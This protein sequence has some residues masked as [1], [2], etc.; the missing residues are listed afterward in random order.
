MI[1]RKRYLHKHNNDATPSPKPAAGDKR[2]IAELEAS[3]A[4]SQSVVRG[5][6]GQLKASGGGRDSD[7]ESGGEH[8]ALVPY[9]HTRTRI[10]KNGRG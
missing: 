6:E 4:E 1:K 10:K 7:G 3:L 5:L 9:G 8:D 2:R